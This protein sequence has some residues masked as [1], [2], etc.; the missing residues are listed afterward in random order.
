M[1]P[2]VFR[3][4]LAE[5]PEGRKGPSPEVGWLASL[6]AALASAAPTCV[7]CAPPEAAGAGSGGRRRR[8]DAAGR[9]CRVRVEWGRREGGRGDDDALAELVAALAHA[10]GPEGGGPH[11]L[12]GDARPP[13]PSG[14][15]RLRLGGSHS[16]GPTLPAGELTWRDLAAAVEAWI[17]RT[18][19]R[20]FCNRVLWINES[21]EDEAEEAEAESEGGEGRG[22][23]R[24]WRVVR[25]RGFGAEETLAAAPA[26]Q[27]FYAARG[28]QRIYMTLVRG[29]FEVSR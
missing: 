8:V 26:R 17:E 3:A 27:P 13:L 11:C 7:P 28:G 10:S 21:E 22:W 1:A 14:R 15:P 24:R 12:R 18:E 23:R 20:V 2:P 29:G 16:R 19:D 4:P 6:L 25:P 9:T 5:G